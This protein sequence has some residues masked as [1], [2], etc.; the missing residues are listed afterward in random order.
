MAAASNLDAALALAE[1]GLAV[2]PCGADRK[3]PITKNGF[4]QASKDPEVISAWWTGWPA[5]NVAIATG[6]ASNVVVLDVD[7]KKGK[8]GESDL[9]VLEKQHGKLPRTVEAITPS[10]GR[11][12]FFRWPGHLVACSVG[13]VAPGLDVRGDGGYVLCAPSHV[14]EADY[15]GRYVWSV[16]SAA[17]FAPLPEWLLTVTAAGAR[18]P[19][20]HFAD[21]ANG[22][23][24][25]CRNDSLASLCG[26]LLRVGL[27]P[28]QA[29][30]YLSFWNSKNNPP[31]EEVVVENAVRNI[32]AREIRKRK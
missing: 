3:T 27:T 8:D 31:L 14:V 22:V 9:R 15:S 28:S 4:K 11:H 12:L 6:A 1:R 10:K 30:E 13:V 18:R 7:T 26:K 19:P 20:G 16:D 23:P 17:E 25:G 24:D 32:A 29:F 5:A 21:I 2:F